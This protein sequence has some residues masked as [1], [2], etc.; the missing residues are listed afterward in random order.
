LLD[1][2]AAPQVNP[3]WI[4]RLL[5]LLMPGDPA[6][7]RR[8]IEI[9]RAEAEA[10]TRNGLNRTGP[11]G[12]F[13]LGGSNFR[14]TNMLEHLANYGIADEADLE[15]IADRARHDPDR[16]VHDTAISCLDA[17]AEKHP[18]ALDMLVSLLGQYP[19][20]CPAAF[21][22]GRMQKK[23]VPVLPRL[24]ELVRGRDKTARV[25][26]LDVLKG[27][28]RHAA[29]AAPAV[30]DAAGHKDP[31][32]REAAL[33]AL[34]AIA[35][36]DPESVATLLAAVNDRNAEVR[37]TA[38]MSVARL[39]SKTPGVLDALR[40]RLADP[41]QD[42][43][44]HALYLLTRLKPLTRAALPLLFGALKDKAANLRS[45]AL[46]GLRPFGTGM[47]GVL[48]AVTEVLRNDPDAAV[49]GAAAEELGR[50]RPFTA[51]GITALRR[52]LKDRAANVVIHQAA[53][54]LGRIGPPAGA[55]LP[56]LHRLA[57]KHP[58]DKAIPRAIERI[59]APQKPAKP[60]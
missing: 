15:V 11:P 18:A 5:A 32:V 23:A 14:R 37:R 9:L 30:R 48:K 31:P 53:A 41:D 57:E 49:R 22:L 60:K 45:L 33:E 10:D 36:A 26:A 19:G 40:S 58:R 3:Y 2:L 39:G 55:A 21:H 44:R 16:N 12:H 38:L 25:Q 24:I 4:V 54:A 43:R 17:L 8:L 46:S 34:A 27:M 59:E 52:A 13:R 20:F 50:L 1:V 42:Q 7:S 51:A 28:G 35:P 29:P 56:D 47:P 6:V